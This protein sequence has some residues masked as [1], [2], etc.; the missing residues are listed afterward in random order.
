M[1][2]VKIGFVLGLLVSNTAFAEAP[3]W[4]R[5][6]ERQIIG[7]DIVHWGT[8]EADSSDVALFKA[9]QMAIKAL[10]E[11]CG[12]IA[13]KDIIPRKQYVES[14]AGTNVGYALVSLDFD[15]CQSGKGKDAKNLQNPEIM[16]EQAMYDKLIGV[17]KDTEEMKVLEKQ[18]KDTI[19][20]GNEIRQE[21]IGSL[22]NEID[23]LRSKV[24]EQRQPAQ[25]AQVA[26]SAGS[27]DAAK[28]M[29]YGQY[30]AMRQQLMAYAQRYHGN[31]A[32]PAL[33]NYYNATR[34]QKLMCDSLK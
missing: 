28:Q 29:C 7:S 4:T 22:K 6:T 25:V 17:K 8:G 5:H 23:Y 16:K 26:P 27:N 18:I 19:R 30:Q 9:R 3:S 20:S 15:S 24:E 12:G 11:E 21:Q 33:F 2:L 1:K 10:I 34:R 13:N 31:V 32:S 14:K